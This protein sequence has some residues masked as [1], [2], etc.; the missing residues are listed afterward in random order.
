MPQL[1]YTTNEVARAIRSGVNRLFSMQTHSGGLGYWPG[2]RAHG[3]G[4]CLRRPRP[5]P[6]RT[7]RLSL[8]TGIT[9]ASWAT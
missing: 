2:R 3:L 5:R 4:Q 9:A 8:P 6:G 7:P 1:Q